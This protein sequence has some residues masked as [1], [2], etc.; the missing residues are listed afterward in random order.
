MFT[1]TGQVSVAYSPEE[2]GVIYWE[3]LKLWPGM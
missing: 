2:K 3:K 1:E